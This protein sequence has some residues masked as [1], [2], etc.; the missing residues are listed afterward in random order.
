MN[1]E[2]KTILHRFYDIC[3]RD[4]VSVLA[5]LLD[6]YADAKA[7]FEKE[8]RMRKHLDQIDALQTGVR[9][10]AIISN[11]ELTKLFPDAGGYAKQHTVPQA[12]IDRLLAENHLP[13]INMIDLF[14]RKEPT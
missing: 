14:N 11:D 2:M 5:V 4:C 3:P 7:K 8:D 9:R 6:E 12:D 13:E 1:Q 10:S